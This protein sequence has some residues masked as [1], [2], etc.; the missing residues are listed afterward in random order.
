MIWSV[1]FGWRYFGCY[2]DDLA[3]M[4]FFWCWQFWYRFEIFFGLIVHFQFNFRYA[5]LLLIKISISLLKY[6]A[7]VIRYDKFIFRAKDASSQLHIE[8]VIDSSPYVLFV[9]LKALQTLGLVEYLAIRS[10]FSCTLLDRCLSEN[11]SSNSIDIVYAGGV[12]HIVLVP[13]LIMILLRFFFSLLVHSIKAFLTWAV[14]KC[15]NQL[16]SNLAI[17]SFAIQNDKLYHCLR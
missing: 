15:L 14:T 10:S 11:G 5:W 7:R 8:C 4:Y 3:W 16:V 1:F 12:E 6:R 2:L 13:R 9:F 17:R